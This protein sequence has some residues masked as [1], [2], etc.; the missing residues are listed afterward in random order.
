MAT[1]ATI[2]TNDGAGVMGNKRWIRG[3]FTTASGDSTIT[4]NS[5]T[6]GGINNI[7]D[8]SVRLD[9]GGVAHQNPKISVSG[10]TI[11]GTVDDTQGYGGTFFVL[12][13]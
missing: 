6:L 8:Y 7:V 10:G 12:G 13:N 3:T 5:N 9:T 1:T 4:I 2:N 11:T